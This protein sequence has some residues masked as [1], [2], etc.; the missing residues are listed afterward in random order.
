MRIK[1]W[2]Y[3]QILASNAAKEMQPFL[4]GMSQSLTSRSTETAGN[5]AL[6]LKIS[7]NLH[8]RQMLEYSL[9]TV[10]NAILN[11]L[12]SFGFWDFKSDNTTSANHMT[13]STTAHKRC[14]LSA[15]RT[16]NSLWQLSQLDRTWYDW[17]K[18]RNK[19]HPVE[20]TGL[21]YSEVKG[22]EI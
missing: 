16:F 7:T 5:E 4:S 1:G 6:F 19:L 2:L 10:W 8:Q 20:I 13:L 22:F 14:H 17:W 9:P 11:N 3:Y 12:L 21:L 18:N 15:D